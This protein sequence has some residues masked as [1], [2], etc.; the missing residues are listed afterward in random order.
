MACS[1]EVQSRLQSFLVTHSIMRQ[2]VVQSNHQHVCGHVPCKLCVL[3]NLK[4]IILSNMSKMAFPRSK[5][6][7]A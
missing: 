1:Y 4:T 6:E 2:H 7:D 3:R 5:T